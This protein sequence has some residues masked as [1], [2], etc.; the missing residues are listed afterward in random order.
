MFYSKP[1]LYDIPIKSIT[2]EGWGDEFEDD[3][4][5]NKKDKRS[6]NSEQPQKEVKDLL[7]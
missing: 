7:G 4:P 1:P 6:E 3:E 5:I 2:P